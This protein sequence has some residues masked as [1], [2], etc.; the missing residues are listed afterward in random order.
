MVGS[1]GYLL[2]IGSGSRCSFT[3][4]LDYPSDIRPHLQLPPAAYFPQ[5]VIKDSKQ[6]S[7]EHAHYLNR[8]PFTT[9]QPREWLHQKKN[10]ETSEMFM[11]NLCLSI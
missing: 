5:Y 6:I 9:T 10:N 11:Y 7:S 8:P 2:I 3:K 1:S 4:I